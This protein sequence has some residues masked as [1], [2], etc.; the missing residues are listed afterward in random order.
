MR[1]FWKFHQGRLLPG[2]PTGP[3]RAGSR[4]PGLPTGLKTVS[5]RTRLEIRLASLPWPRHWSRSTMQFFVPERFA[6]RRSLSKTC[7]LQS[8]HSKMLLGLPTQTH[9]A[10]TS[11]EKFASRPPKLLCEDKNKQTI[12][13]QALQITPHYFRTT[14]TSI[15][16]AHT[17]H[18]ALLSC[19]K[20]SRNTSGQHFQFARTLRKLSHESLLPGRHTGPKLLCPE[21]FAA[22]PSFRNKP[23]LHFFAGRVRWKA[24]PLAPSSTESAQQ[25]EC[26][27]FQLAPL[28]SFHMHRCQR[29]PEPCRNYAATLRKLSQESSMLGFPD[30]PNLFCKFSD[31]KDCC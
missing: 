6:V 9:F 28:I 21:S 27:A 23:T 29:A 2:L 1:P 16:V 11:P 8:L 12:R 17:S 5:K 24:F 18:R 3:N 20:I 22:G 30:G 14:S 10:K 15:I 7:T 13:Y 19:W 26:Q 4:L 31:R 25:I